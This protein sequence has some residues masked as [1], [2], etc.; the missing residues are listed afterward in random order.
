[1]Q[2]FILSV[3]AV[4][5]ASASIAQSAQAAPKVS[6]DFDLQTLRL[7]ELDTRNKSEEAPQPYYPEASTQAS[8][9]NTSSEAD[10]TQTAESAE[11]KAPESQE[12]AASASL[13]LTEQRHQSLDRS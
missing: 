9:Q 11:W 13:S 4:L 7:G 1:M 2:R 10:S 12:E 5:L 8:P 6:P 3:S